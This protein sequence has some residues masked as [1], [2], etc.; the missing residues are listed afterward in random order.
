MEPVTERYLLR[1]LD[2]EWRAIVADDAKERWLAALS[3]DRPVLDGLGSLGDLV[4]VVRTG[5]VER[6]TEIVWELLDVAVDDPF[7]VRLL[8]QCIVPGLNTEVRRLTYWVDQ[9]RVGDLTPAEIDGLLL[10]ATLEAIGGA[11]GKRRNWPIKSILRRT[12]RILERDLRIEEEWLR[13]VRLEDEP[14]VLHHVQLEL[15]PAEAL[16]E[17]L[18]DATEQGVVAQRDAELVWLVAVE[19]Y[20]AEELQDHF[21]ATY[22]CLRQR[23]HRAASRLAELRAA[24]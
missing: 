21:G 18:N 2:V 3:L 20:A 14:L 8:L 13:R 17:L 6:S 9:L 4:A 15:E 19:G 16:A 5:T 22:A 11:V 24:G 7:A 12:H 1:A 23:Q 10:A